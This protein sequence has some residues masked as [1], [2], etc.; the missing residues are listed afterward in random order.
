M[1]IFTWEPLDEVLDS[2]FYNKFRN[3]SHI[4]VSANN[5]S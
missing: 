5:L 3:N 4:A 1:K 2:M